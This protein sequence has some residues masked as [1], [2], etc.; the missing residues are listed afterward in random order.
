MTKDD[1][2]EA[3]KRLM[4]DVD[5]FDCLKQFT[6]I[7]CSGWTISTGSLLPP[8]LRRAID[9]EGAEPTI[10]TVLAYARVPYVAFDEVALLSLWQRIARGDVKEGNMKII[11]QGE[12]VDLNDFFCGVVQ[13][14]ALYKG[15]H[16]VP[17]DDPVETYVNENTSAGIH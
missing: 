7:V 8:V 1:K 10:E 14:Y 11:L 4:N 13:A 5:G 15:G 17:Y 2:I 12:D 3:L 9:S 6:E 16:G